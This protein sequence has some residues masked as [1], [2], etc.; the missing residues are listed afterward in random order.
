M[1][2]WRMTLDGLPPKLLGTGTQSHFRAASYGYKATYG[3]RG[4]PEVATMRALLRLRRRRSRRSWRSPTTAA[5]PST[6]RVRYEFDCDFLDLFEVKSRE[7]GQRDLAFAKT[8][9]PLPTSRRYDATE[10][11]YDFAVGGERLPRPAR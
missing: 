3:G 8:I 7:F 10:N 6:A 11:S 1:S 9:T 2:L 5:R 4:A